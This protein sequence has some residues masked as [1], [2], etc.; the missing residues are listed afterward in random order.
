[1]GLSPPQ[2][3]APAKP[4][5]HAGF[6]L[7]SRDLAGPG[8][9]TSVTGRPRVNGWCNPRAHPRRTALRHRASL[10]AGSP[11][12]VSVEERR[13]GVFR[14]PPARPSTRCQTRSEAPERPRGV[15]TPNSNHFLTWPLL[16]AAQRRRE[17]LPPNAKQTLPPTSA[18]TTTASPDKNALLYHGLLLFSCSGQRPN[19]RPPAM[20]T[21][22][23][24]AESL[25]GCTATLRRGDSIPLCRWSDGVVAA[26]GSTVD[27]GFPPGVTSRPRGAW[28]ASHMLRGG[29][30]A[31]RRA[32][33]LD[34][35][36]RPQLDLG[37]VWLCP[38]SIGPEASGSRLRGG[39][40]PPSGR[41]SPRHAASGRPSV[42]LPLRGRW[43]VPEQG[44]S[45]RS[46]R[47]LSVVTRPSMSRSKRRRAFACDGSRCVRRRRRGPAVNDALPAGLAASRSFDEADEACTEL[48]PSRPCSVNRTAP[49][50]CSG[51]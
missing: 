11:R 19:A 49:S 8:P 28:S 32:S 31:V 18:S 25:D 23:R 13:N 38:P 42:P 30:F 6:A 2:A 16:Q 14:H 26:A 15:F 44:Q 9:C 40:R 24:G 36:A 50:E 5:I 12:K 17:R 43:L 37:R 3:G 47:R 20:T 4:R 34:S 39:S 27:H 33:V 41:P 22:R 48:A 35:S 46:R 29:M 21:D 10:G 45:S 51:R 1:M 7:V